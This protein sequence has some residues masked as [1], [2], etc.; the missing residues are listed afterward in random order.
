MVRRKCVDIGWIAEQTRSD[1]GEDIQFQTFFNGRRD[2]FKILCQVKS[3]SRRPRRVTL[4]LDL[5]RNWTMM[6]DIV[7][8][9]AWIETENKYLVYLPNMIFDPVHIFESPKKT[10]S[11][12][13]DDFFSMES[14]DDWNALEWMVR[15]EATARGFLYANSRINI[16]IDDNFSSQKNQNFL[17]LRA[18]YAN[19][20]LK[21]AGLSGK[22]SVF[23][24]PSNDKSKWIIDYVTSICQDDSTREAF[25]KN[26]E[27]EMYNLIIASLIEQEIPLANPDHFLFKFA[28]QWLVSLI[29]IELESRGE[30]DMSIFYAKE[31]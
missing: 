4:K 7:L 6:L 15:I 3:F 23:E 14:L 16:S 2:P 9:V 13:Y 18:K 8:L 30:V 27:S 28:A 22:T 21:W 12:N 17:Y 29:S 11:V 31:Y 10:I 1:F 25:G 5:I 20:V 26:F 19:E 24:F